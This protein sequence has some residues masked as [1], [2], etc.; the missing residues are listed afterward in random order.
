MPVV[1]AAAADLRGHRAGCALL[2]LAWRGTRRARGARGAACCCW[3]CRRRRRRCGSTSSRPQSASCNLTL[4]DR[5]VTGAAARRAAA[6]RV[7]GRARSC[8]DA[9][10]DLLGVPYEFWSLALFVVLG[11]AVVL[12]SL[13]AAGLTLDASTSSNAAEVCSCPPGSVCGQRV[14]RCAAA[15]PRSSRIAPAPCIDAVG[16]RQRPSEPAW[17][18][19]RCRRERS[20][21]RRVRDSTALRWPACRWQRAGTRRPS[22]SRHSA[23]GTRADRGAEVDAK[24][25][26]AVKARLRRKAGRHR[27]QSAHRPRVPQRL[28]TAPAAVRLRRGS[29]AHRLDASVQLAALARALADVALRARRPSALR[30]SACRR[31]RCPCTCSASAN[32]A[33]LTSS[34]SFASTSISVRPRPPLGCSFSSSSGEHQQA[35]GQRQAGDLRVRRQHRRRRQR[36]LARPRASG[37]SCR[38]AGGDSRSPTCASRPK[39][40]VLASSSVCVGRRRRSSAPAACRTRGRSAS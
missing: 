13:R 24:R 33:T 16:A 27:R 32:A 2:G 14:A 31:G 38:R 15:R 26:R 10:V 35:P 1:R 29:D 30:P 18:G 23:R 36:L 39:P 21:G 5:I 11:A 7:P 9:A 6:R 20:R 19:S 4:A 8:A 12:C 37:R 28:P 3:R 17:S 22:P 25:V 34:G 40:P